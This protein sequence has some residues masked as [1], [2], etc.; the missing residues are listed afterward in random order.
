M[1]RLNGTKKVRLPSLGLV[2][3]PDRAA[4]LNWKLPEVEAHPTSL[5]KFLGSPLWLR[6]TKDLSVALYSFSVSPQVFPFLESLT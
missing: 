1:Q 5:R 2:P 4:I 6:V 3:L